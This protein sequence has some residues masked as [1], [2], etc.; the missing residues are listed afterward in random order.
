MKDLNNIIETIASIFT[1]D[2]GIV[3]VLLL[4]KKNDPYKGYWILPSDILTVHETAEE[5]INN[6]ISKITGL[7]DLNYMQCHT[8]SNLDRDPD[9]RILAISFVALI[10]STTVNMKLKTDSEVEFAWF[11]IQNIP[12]LGYDHK[13][14]VDDAIKFFQEN[15]VNSNTLKVLFPSDFTLPELQRVYEQ[16]LNTKLDRR[17]FRKKFV[18]LGLVKDT[19]DKNEKTN[20]RPAKLYT[21]CDDTKERILF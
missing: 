12:K 21:F 7:E 10:D 5:N 20:G 4:K 9:N 1:I 6:V 3:K 13:I 16:I 18:N 11:A 17:N 15:I 2:E 8:Y 14:I 19:G